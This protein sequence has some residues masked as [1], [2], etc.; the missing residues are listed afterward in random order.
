MLGPRRE[1]S[2]PHQ[3]VRL[4]TNMKHQKLAVGSLAKKKITKQCVLLSKVVRGVLGPRRER[5]DPHK[6]LRLCTRMKCQP[7]Q[8]LRLHTNMKRQKLAVGSLAKKYNET[9]VFYHRK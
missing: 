5:S 3:V 9:Y 7:H 4:R 6:V 8:V 2:E 1:R